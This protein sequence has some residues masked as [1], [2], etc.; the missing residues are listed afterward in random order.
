[1]AEMKS[2]F[3]ALLAFSLCVSVFTGCETTSVN[4]SRVPSVPRPPTSKP[5]ISGK[6]NGSKTDLV[7]LLLTGDPKAAWSLGER[8][9]NKLEKYKWWTLADV[10]SLTN[11]Q[12]SYRLQESK[13]LKATITSAADQ[14]NYTIWQKKVMATYKIGKNLQFWLLELQQKNLLPR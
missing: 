8:A 3:I 13:R 5:T 7:K 11:D 9:P 10:I 6:Y 2:T 12:R 14:R 4:P 1:M